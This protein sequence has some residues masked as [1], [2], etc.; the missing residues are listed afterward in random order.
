[1]KKERQLAKHLGTKR[2]EYAYLKDVF[3][4]LRVELAVE[5]QRSPK[6][7]PYVPAEDELR[8]WYE[9]H[10]TGLSVRVGSKWT[11]CAWRTAQSTVQ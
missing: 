2:P 4:N 8:R 10:T 7:L 9:L 11:P 6:K 3:R 5:V 1:M